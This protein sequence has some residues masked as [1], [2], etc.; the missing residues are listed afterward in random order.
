M[1]ALIFKVPL[2]AP[3]QDEA[4]LHDACLELLPGR[5]CA[6]ALVRLGKVLFAVRELEVYQRLGHPNFAAWLQKRLGIK[7]PQPE[8]YIKIK[9]L[10]EDRLAGRR[11]SLHRLGI[12]ADDQAGPLLPALLQFAATVPEPRGRDP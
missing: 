1:D 2:Q 7:A 11:I 4:L 5:H 12:M 6:D 10:P 9:D 8:R 3:G